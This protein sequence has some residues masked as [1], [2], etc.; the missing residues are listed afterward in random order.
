MSTHIN[1]GTCVHCGTDIHHDIK[2]DRLVHTATG[3]ARCDAQGGY[4]HQAPFAT[5]A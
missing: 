4:I 1:P 3:R 5:R 2:R